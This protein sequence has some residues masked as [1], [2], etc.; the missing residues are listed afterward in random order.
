MPGG[1]F[2]SLISEAEEGGETELA[3]LFKKSSKKEAPAYDYTEVDSQKSKAQSS[4]DDED[5]SDLSDL[6][7]VEEEDESTLSHITSHTPK[8][9][10]PIVT[11]STPQHHSNTNKN[12]K[13]ITNNTYAN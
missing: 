12:Y 8:P 3:D 1:Q 7:D 4:Q 11:T 6:G 10:L 9:P 13:I 5:G 2:F